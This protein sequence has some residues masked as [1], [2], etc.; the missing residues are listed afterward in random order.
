MAEASLGRL[1]GDLVADLGRL[2]RQELRL[3]GAEASEKVAQAER[4]LYA[5]AFG[6][7]ASL[8]ALIFL[9]QAVVTALS[10]FLPTW[11][12]SSLVGLGLAALA[13]FLLCYG[14]RSLRA[15]NLLPKRTLGSLQGNDAKARSTE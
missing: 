12:S 7:V 13:V 5:S 3:A 2:V 4:G 11:L 9:F 10:E 8:C 6:L 14:R 1:L 15:R